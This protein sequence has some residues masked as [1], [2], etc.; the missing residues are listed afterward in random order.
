MVQMIHVRGLIL[1]TDNAQLTWSIS[2]GK[3]NLLW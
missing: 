1:D 3:L 2:W